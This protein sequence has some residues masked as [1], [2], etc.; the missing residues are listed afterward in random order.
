MTNEYENLRTWEDVEFAELMEYNNS[1]THLNYQ[2][3]NY[4]NYLFNC[5][6][7]IKQKL[8]QIMKEE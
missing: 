4:I 3:L 7:S 1:L 6:A 2:Y 5:Q 8:Q